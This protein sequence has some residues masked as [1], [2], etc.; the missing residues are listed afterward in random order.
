MSSK[1]RI[2]FFEESVYKAVR[3][4]PRGRAATYAAVA[5]AVGNPRGARAVGNALNRN[6]FRSVPCHR[7]IRSDRSIGGYARGTA[8]KTK[9]L[10]REGVRIRN[11]RVDSQCIVIW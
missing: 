7:V 10:L 4:I 8:E 9:I 2:T 11:G 6:I 1:K 5:G 3:R